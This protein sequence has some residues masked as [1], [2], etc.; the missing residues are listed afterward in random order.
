[1]HLLAN[2]LPEVEGEGAR[3]NEEEETR[4]LDREVVCQVVDALFERQ[5]SPSSRS[6]ALLCTRCASVAS[7]AAFL[8]CRHVR[9]VVTRFSSS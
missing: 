7:V 3:G 9:E 8:H 4:P 2:P 1:M 6:T 5:A